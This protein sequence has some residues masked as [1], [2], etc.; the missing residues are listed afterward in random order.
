MS[1]RNVA[2]VTEVMELWN[3]WGRDPA[4]EPRLL[5]IVDPDVR[6]DMTRRVLNPDVYEGH[7][8]MRRLG[9]EVAEVWDEFSVVPDRFVDAGDHVV[10]IETRRGRGKGSGVEVETRAA[11][12]WSVRDGRVTAMV[13]HDDPDE[14]LR[15]AGAAPE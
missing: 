4:V 11:A 7:E 2:V 8:G 6:I 13:A 1:E 9:R 14:A 3:D 15:S 5:E 10:V 12:V